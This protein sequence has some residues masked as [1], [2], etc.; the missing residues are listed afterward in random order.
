MSLIRS[1]A[2]LVQEGLADLAGVS[3]AANHH[4]YLIAAEGQK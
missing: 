2:V 4:K 1:L 3:E